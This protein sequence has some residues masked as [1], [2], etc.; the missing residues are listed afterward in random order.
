MSG[1]TN[2][3]SQLPVT[4]VSQ[5]TEMEVSK[6]NEALEKELE[7]SE[8]LGFADQVRVVR[9]GFKRGVY[10]DGCTGVPDFDFGADCCGEHDFHY[11]Q[12][13]IS[14]AEADKRLRQCI[15]K[16]GYII[17]PWV[18]WLGVRIF[19]RKYYRTKQNETFPLAEPNA[20]DNNS[21]RDIG[22]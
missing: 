6:A 20:I 4:E 2:E 10:Y 5:E 8:H 18:F 15:R 11:Q 12:T 19:G 3:L 17:L 9:E 13:D 21:V 7:K 14:R 1:P 22:G 16:K